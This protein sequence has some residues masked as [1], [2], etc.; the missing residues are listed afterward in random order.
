[1]AFDACWAKIDEKNATFYDQRSRIHG[2]AAS[3]HNLSS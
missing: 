3:H 1:M 2:A